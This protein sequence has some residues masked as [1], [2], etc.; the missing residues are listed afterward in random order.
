HFSPTERSEANRATLAAI[1]VLVGAFFAR[2]GI[3]ALGPA[4]AHRYRHGPPNAIEIPLTVSWIGYTFLLATAV[5]VVI[6]PFGLRQKWRLGNLQT[7]LVGAFSLAVLVAV[8]YLSFTP[9]SSRPELS[10][11]IGLR[12]SPEDNRL[13]GGGAGA[14]FMNR[15]KNYV[16]HNRVEVSSE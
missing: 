12:I 2:W 11:T 15:P 14:S 1:S 6:V 7:A 13:R 16:F 5:L 4:L 10:P 3:T 8:A 9:L